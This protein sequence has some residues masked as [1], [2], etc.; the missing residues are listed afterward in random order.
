MWKDIPARMLYSWEGVSKIKTYP[1]CRLEV[2]SSVALDMLVK[3]WLDL[4]RILESVAFEILEDIRGTKHS[5][6]SRAT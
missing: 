1:N 6:P 3:C 5:V 2:H 4:P